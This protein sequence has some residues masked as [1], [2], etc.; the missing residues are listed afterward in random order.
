LTDGSFS[1]PFRLVERNNLVTF[2]RFNF[3]LD[4]TKSK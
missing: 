3:L 1:L 4:P 2:G